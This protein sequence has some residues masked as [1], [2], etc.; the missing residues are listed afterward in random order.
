MDKFNDSCIIFVKK[1]FKIYTLTTLHLL[2]RE[3]SYS[4]IKILRLTTQLKSWS[5]EQLFLTLDSKDEE[6]NNDQIMFPPLRAHPLKIKAWQLSMKTK[7][8]VGAKKSIHSFVSDLIKSQ[9]N[10]IRS[11]IFLKINS[12]VKK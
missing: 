6:E 8:C 4:P 9:A 12:F 5:Q 1:I 2:K 11:Y 3:F 7:T 10:L